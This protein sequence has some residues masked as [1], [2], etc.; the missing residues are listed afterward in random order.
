M[1]KI[2]KLNLKKQIFSLKFCYEE[3]LIQIK[4]LIGKVHNLTNVFK[5]TKN[6]I[7][8][9]RKNDFDFEKEKKYILIINQKKNLIKNIEKLSRTLY[10]SILFNK[11]QEMQNQKES[12]IQE[13][14]EKKNQLN[15]LKNDLNIFKI[16]SS[17]KIPASKIYLNSLQDSIITN[18]N[19]KLNNINNNHS[20]IEKNLY[21][22][23]YKEKLNLQKKCEEVCNQMKI[24]KNNSL[25]RYR[26]M[27][28]ENGFNSCII[29][30]KNNKTYI[31][32]VQPIKDLNNNS[33]DDSDSEDNNNTKD[34]SNSINDRIFDIDNKNKNKKLLNKSFVTSNKKNNNKKNNYL[35]NNSVLYKTDM[36]KSNYNNQ[37]IALNNTNIKNFRKYKLGL[38]TEV[39]NR[40]DEEL[41]KKLLK[42]KESYYKCLDQ[43]YE[44]KNSLKSN[45]SQ[46]YKMKEKIKKFKKENINK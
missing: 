16:Y 1:D 28:K 24:L 25:M 34:I 31:F 29:N 27:I 43:R 12:L 18:P 6:Y 46:I 41:N 14:E 15:S 33:S 10:K 7:K 32:T 42:I 19:N 40:N 37:K 44:L 26:N 21:N 39:D 30:K 2:K 20:L 38:V 5:L 9:K 45:I 17:Y 4:S 35:Y 8:E 13:L 3:Q 22:L 36:K 23:I 11:F